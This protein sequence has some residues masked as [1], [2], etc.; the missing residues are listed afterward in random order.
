MLAEEGGHDKIHSSSITPVVRLLLMVVDYYLRFVCIIVQYFASVVV[1]SFCLPRLLI[2]C[3]Q[4]PNTTLLVLNRIAFIVIITL[5]NYC[6]ENVEKGE[7][8]FGRK[9]DTFSSLRQTN[10]DDWGLDL[11]ELRFYTAQMVNVWSAV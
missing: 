11:L 4:F 5:G 9:T 2:K 6:V 8:D 7:V 10:C 1:Q 3:F